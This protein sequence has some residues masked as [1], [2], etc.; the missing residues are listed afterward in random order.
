VI[1]EV[2]SDMSSWIKQTKGADLSLCNSVEPE[3]VKLLAE[4][5]SYKIKQEAK[6]LSYEMNLAMSLALKK[7]KSFLSNDYHTKSYKKST[8]RKL[9][10]MFGKLA[11][12][13]KEKEK[14]LQSVYGAKIEKYE[15]I[16]EEKL[17][18][19]VINGEM[20]SVGK[21][22]QCLDD[23]IEYLGGSLRSKLNSFYLEFMSEKNKY[24][25]HYYANGKKKDGKINVN[26][27]NVVK[28]RKQYSWKHVMNSVGL[29]NV[30]F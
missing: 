28:Q 10:L 9:K 4:E 6:D 17:D 18:G 19:E 3:A 21:F 15:S 2:S 1:R 11:D 25:S 27:E 30:L 13:D 23:V 26:D 22:K 20:V 16:A 8:V 14:L 29:Q 5:I 24:A 7:L 12:S